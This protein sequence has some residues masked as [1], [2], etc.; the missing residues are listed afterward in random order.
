MGQSN[1]SNKKSEKT[2]LLQS[3]RILKRAY[4]L[5]H[6]VRP[7]FLSYTIA[8]SITNALKPLIALFMSARVIN[9]LAGE[10]DI[11]RIMLY[12]SITVLSVFLLSVL[13]TMCKKK[14]D[15]IN[16]FNDNELEFLYAKRYLR[17][18]YAH[19]EDHHVNKMLAD[20]RGRARG[21]G[22]GFV[23]IFY[24]T[25]DLISDV[26]TLVISLAMLSGTLVTTGETYVRNWITSP[27]AMS[28][29][30]V[31]AVISL[32]VPLFTR[33]ITKK[34]FEMVERE[35]PK[36]NALFHYYHEYKSV[37]K[38]AKDIRLYHQADAVMDIFEKRLDSNIWTWFFKRLGYQS[39]LSG[40]VS[41]FVGGAVY[42]FIGLRTL[43]GMYP[44]GS[45]VMYVG[46]VANVIGSIS[47]ISENTGT[48]MNNIPYINNV[49]E[50]L[51]LSEPR[52]TG[53]LK[54]DFRDID[55]EFKNV[56]FMY[57]GADSYALKNIDLRFKYGQRLAVVG[58]NGSGKTTMIK[59]LCRL[60]CPTA[61][62]ISFNGLTSLR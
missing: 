13:H 16:E 8:T 9:E 45:M 17:M 38:A 49:Y 14:L 53:A 52:S 1:E 32:V 21:N 34:A 12:V 56:S 54:P 43:Y 41:A 11:R 18:D 25:P 40:A 10:R 42:I 30:L 58:E 61:G 50:F 60:Y 51:D 46:A 36:K 6:Q 5:A 24:T 33:K 15:L 23:R 3:I 22:L 28:F 57:P 2:T 59:L 29:L 48:I 44:V 62:V 31:L 26:S 27:W 55:I 4:C 39:G 35:N 7:G 20:I 37:K 19:I 47:D